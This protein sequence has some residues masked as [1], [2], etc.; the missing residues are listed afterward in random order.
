MDSNDIR[1]LQALLE[2]ALMKENRLKTFA[3]I[4]SISYLDAIALE[5]EE[6]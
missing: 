5:D 2:R 1:K 6:L 4:S 3:E